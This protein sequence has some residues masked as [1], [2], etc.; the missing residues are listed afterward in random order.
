[1]KPKVVPHSVMLIVASICAY[2]QTYQ[3]TFENAR[4]LLKQSRYS[5]ALQ[6]AGRATKMDGSQ[7]GAYFVAGAALVGLDRQ[8]EAIDQFQAALARAPEQAKATINQAIA[9]C[10]QIL[11]SRNERPATDSPPPSAPAQ[12]NPAPTAQ[13]HGHLRIGEPPTTSGRRGDSVQVRIPLATEPGYFVNSNTPTAAYL[14]PLK[15]T[16]I[17]LGELQ[18]GQVAY[19]TPSLAKSSFAVGPL[20][21]FFDNFDIVAYF[22]IPASA[23]AG[24]GI[25]VGKLRFQPCNGASC[26]RPQTVDV[27]VPYS[28]Q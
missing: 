15:L 11:S 12:S 22:R 21:A 3:S 17:S 19:P 27:K 24:P 7:W 5:E 23:P 2:G 8:A 6:E 10:R 28:I 1:M 20:S 26:F 18:G 4:A 14:I 16:W 9:A 25:A 13:F